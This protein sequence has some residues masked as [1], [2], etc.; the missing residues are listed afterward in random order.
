MWRSIYKTANGRLVSVGSVWKDPL[1]PDEAFLELPDRPDQGANMWDETT[2]DWV[3]RP[4]KVF[5][6]RLD[7]IK[8]HPRFDKFKQV[9]QGLAPAKKQLLADVIIVWLGKARWRNQSESIIID[10]EPGDPDA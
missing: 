6:D 1:P 8:T 4:P 3:V 10:P 2:R 7:D 5:A 9:W